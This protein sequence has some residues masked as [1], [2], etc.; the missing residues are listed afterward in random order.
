MLYKY[1]VLNNGVLR[2]SVIKE[3]YDKGKPWAIRGR[4]V[5]GLYNIFLRRQE[6]IKKALL[7]KMFNRISLQ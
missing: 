1:L 3:H 4:K 6:N 2:S 5:K 7:P